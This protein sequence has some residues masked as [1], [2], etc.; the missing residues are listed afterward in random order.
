MISPVQGQSQILET[1]IKD[2][3]DNLGRFGVENAES[4]FRNLASKAA[5]EKKTGDS[6]DKSKEEKNL[7]INYD[8]I[9]NAL[10]GLLEEDNLSIKFSVDEDTQKMIMRL[11]DAK[12]KEVV[13]QYPPEITLKIARIVMNSLGNGNIANAQV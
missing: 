5:G 9:G 10:E 13:Q 2:S 6:S 3:G 11:I 12:T 4:T 7:S 1:R 8:E